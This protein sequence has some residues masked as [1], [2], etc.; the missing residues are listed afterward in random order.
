LRLKAYATLH[1]CPIDLPLARSAVGRL[2]A[3]AEAPSRLNVEDIQQIV[4]NYFDIKRNDLLGVSRAKK[5]CEPRHIAQY[6]ARKMTSLSLPDIGQRFGGRDH[7][8][9]L[10]ACKRIERN[11]EKD[12][13][14]ANLV[15][16]LTKQLKEKSGKDN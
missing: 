4:C 8:S 6:L 5:F 13:N 15:N 1:E 14:L 9:I 7:T 11:M 3:T 16:H 2:L 12:P 10:H